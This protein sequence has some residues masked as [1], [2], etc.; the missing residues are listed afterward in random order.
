MTECTCTL[1]VD[2]WGEGCW[3][4]RVKDTGSVVAYE[5]CPTVMRARLGDSSAAR[6]GRAG[7]PPKYQGYTRAALEDFEPWP[8]WAAEYVAHP[9]GNV[10]IHGP[11]GT[12]KTHL[13]VAILDELLGAGIRCAYATAKLLPELAP[14]RVDDDRDEE[15]RLRSVPVLLVD[16]LF[17]ETAYKADRV[18]NL[19]EVRYRDDLA[20]LYTSMLPIGDALRVDSDLASRALSG[21]KV[22]RGGLDRRIFPRAVNGR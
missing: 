13:A 19:A 4:L 12:G 18:R 14:D 7:V 22:E 1:P 2:H 10:Y 6:L 17:S 3:H 15:A 20:T 8:T 21:R 5:R 16:D 11:N 9:E